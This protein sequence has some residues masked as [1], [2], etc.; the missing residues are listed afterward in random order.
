MVKRWW[1]ETYVVNKV[2]TR[3]LVSSISFSKHGSE[4]NKQK[5]N[6]TTTLLFYDFFGALIVDDEFK[7]PD[8]LFKKTLLE[9]YKNTICKITKN[10]TELTLDKSTSFL[11]RSKNHL[12]NQTKNRMSFE[13]AATVQMTTALQRLYVV[14]YKYML[15]QWFHTSENIQFLY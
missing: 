13:I 2:A 14:S 5:S 12:S 6:F 4:N 11:D 7:I 15:H 3:S 8:W 10:D 1:C 9:K